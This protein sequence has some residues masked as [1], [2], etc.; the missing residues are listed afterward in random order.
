MWYTLWQHVS[1]CYHTHI[2]PEENSRPLIQR[3][4]APSSASRL[5]QK[6][7]HLYGNQQGLTLVLTLLLLAVL[8]ITG[9]T[10]V[11]MTSSDVLL[12]GNYKQSQV[13][14]YNAE[15]GVHYTLASLP[16]LIHHGT[17]ALDGSRATEDYGF[18]S[19]PGLT[20]QLAT[21]A[22]FTRVAQ[23]RQ[24]VFQVTGRPQA[25]SP[26]HTTLEVVIQRQSAL[27]YGLFGD[28]QVDLP[29]GGAITGAVGSNGRVS[30]H[31][32]EG[33]IAVDGDIALGADTTGQRAVL[34]IRRTAETLDEGV[35]TV[36]VGGERELSLRQ[37]ARIHAD[38]LDV[39][40][41]VDDASLHLIASNDNANVA[42]ITSYALTQGTTLP[43]GAYYLDV[44]ELGHGQ[45]LTLDAS[46]GDVTIYTQSLSLT[47]DA[48]LVIH[49]TGSGNVTLYLDGPGVFGAPNA[50]LQPTLT[51][52]GPPSRFR[53]FSRS[54]EALSF[55]HRGDLK[56]LIY[57]PL[58]PV[59]VHNASA[60][61][62]GLIWGK[63]ILLPEAQPFTFETDSAV[64]D[65][66]LAPEVAMVSW[67]DMRS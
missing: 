49:V 36:A 35:T 21:E 5:P 59:T 32:R 62:V 19:P 16:H 28:N 23:T 26:L 53:L 13:A 60:R 11:I 14:F 4:A 55:Y 1:D 29:T 65:L 40:A 57:A 33:S 61:A 34:T 31:S 52:L 20:F 64:Q 67:K 54:R 45:T 12:G 7:G 43:S 50:A 44:I 15:A 48:H 27:P 25:N 42:A 8:T 3:A 9:A 58:A 18:A 63:T 39:E 56:G 22:T 10:A 51:I 47:D 30:L 41:L 17:L 2:E 66:F 38:P 24:Y 6:F 46:A 37:V